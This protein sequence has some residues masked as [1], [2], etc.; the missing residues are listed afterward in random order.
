M[1]NAVTAPAPSRAQTTTARRRFRRRS[2]LVAALPAA[3][4]AVALFGTWWM[5]LSLASLVAGWEDTA[6][7]L[8]RMFPPTFGNPGDIAALL[9]QTLLIALAGTGLAALASVPLAAAAA[10]T[11][12]GSRPVQT[13]AR[14]V[15]VLTRAVPSLVFAIIFV[16][17]FGLGPMAGGLAIAFHS[18]GMIA[19]MLADSFEEQDRL[20]AEAARAA[21]LNRLQVFAATVWSR[22]VPAFTSIVL[23]RLDINIRASAVLGLV[24][25]GGI[26][27]ALQSAM[28][29]LNY[30][31][32]AG[33]VL[34]IIALI[35]LLEA[36]SVAIQRRVSTH[37]RA[38]T[39]PVLLPAGRES[40]QPGWDVRRGGRLALGLSAVALFG[41]ALWSLEAD[42]SRLQDS[43]P[44]VW[45]L[46]SG[47]FPPAFSTDI[48]IGV[49]ESL[50]MAM[51]ATVAGVLVGLPLALV[52][53]GLLLGNRALSAAVR[54][55][56]VLMRGVPDIVYALLF[57]AALG[58]GPFAGFLALAISCTALAAKFFT[59]SLE[60]LDPAPRQALEATGASK[61]Q[62]LVSGVWPQ[63]FPSFLG[64][65]LFTSDLAL[66]ESAVLGIVGAGGVGFLL[67]ESTATLHYETTSAILVCLIVVVFAIESAARW[68]RRQVF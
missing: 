32:A 48:L 59:D 68:V 55:L 23:Y 50:V 1:A 49:M 7:L 5:D 11:F 42:W 44:N 45:I 8:G 19:K 28:G 56:V 51:T 25:A 3:Y 26:G 43:L 54:T 64:N 12:T 65:G 35:L 10:S 66:R 30:R 58:L 36:I 27:V 15:I 53:T 47:M 39:N 67:H 34:V 29:S 52:S 38:G 33:I 16:R 14:A 57:V 13:A 41:Y 18:V 40:H 31:R 22:A 20:P 61:L 60:G 62:V 6:R 17:V 9:V 37:S 2:L 46:V 21:G 24:G 4:L 63:F